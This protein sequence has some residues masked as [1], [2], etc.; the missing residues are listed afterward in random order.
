MQK[1]PKMVRESAIL[2][3][4]LKAKEQEKKRQKQAFQT[5]RSNLS[6]FACQR[7]IHRRLGPKSQSTQA[8]CKEFALPLFRQF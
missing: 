6:F 7:S 4:F 2:A 1:N 5:F 3:N 8:K